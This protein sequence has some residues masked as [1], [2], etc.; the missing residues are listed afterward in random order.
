MSPQNAAIAIAFWVPL[1]QSCVRMVASASVVLCPACCKD[2]KTLVCTRPSALRSPVAIPRRCCDFKS[3]GV[4]LAIS[5]DGV[6]I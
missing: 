4:M 3:Q 6:V 1:S 2:S 5:K